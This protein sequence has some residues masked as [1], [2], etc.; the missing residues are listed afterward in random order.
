MALEDIEEESGFA[1]SRR[2]RRRSGGGGSGPRR[3]RCLLAAGFLRGGH[4]ARGTASEPLK[5]VPLTTLPGV[6]RYPSFSPDGN[7][8]A[9]TWNGP[10]QD[11]PD[12]YVQQIGAGA[13]LRLTTDPRNDYNPVWS[14]DGRW[15]A[16]LRESSAGKSELRLIPPLGGPERKLARSGYARAFSTPPYLA[17]CPDSNCL[18]VTDSPGEGRPDALFVVSLETGE[19]RQL[20]NPQ[21]PMLATS[22]RRSRPTAVRWFSAGTTAVVIGELYWLRFEKGRDALS[23]EAPAPHARRAGCELSRLDA[24]RQE[25]FSFP[26]EEAFGGWLSR[27]KTTPARLPLWARTG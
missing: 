5:A 12:I 16:F 27:A 23:G 2:R 22:I 15:I 25:R 24:R 8:V 9:F 10:K 1:D 21:P 7:H 19:K 13:P 20:T 17:W 3:C 11:N 14:P 4:G 26:P 6:E 18:V